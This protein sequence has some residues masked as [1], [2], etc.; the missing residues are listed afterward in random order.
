MNEC[1]ASSG[2]SATEG[3]LFGVAAASS[4]RLDVGAVF[5]RL[6]GPVMEQAVEVRNGGAG[7]KEYGK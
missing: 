3:A 4:G 7:T 2:G 1:G 5:V 6:P